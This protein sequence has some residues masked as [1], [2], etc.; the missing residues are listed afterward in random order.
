MESLQN[1]GLSEAGKN[2][3]EDRN[4]LTMKKRGFTLLEVLIVIIIIGILAAIALPQYTKTLERA[5]SAEAMTN[6]GVLRGSMMRYWYEQVAAGDY[7][8]PEDLDSLDVGN[9]NGVAEANRKWDYD[10]MVDVGNNNDAAFILRAQ[11]LGDDTT[12]IQIDDD[13]NIAKSTNLG[14]TGNDLD[15]QAP[16]RG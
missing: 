9:P 6:L 2:N 11:R 15:V 12:W 3:I 4:G 16:Q 13:G 10:V 14:G 1:Q 5:K 8:A 7:D